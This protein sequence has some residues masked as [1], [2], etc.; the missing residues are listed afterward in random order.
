MKRTIRLTESDLHRIVKECVN[1]ALNEV[2]YGGESFHGDNPEDWDAIKQIRQKRLNRDGNQPYRYKD[3]DGVLRAN[4]TIEDNFPNYRG[5]FSANV[6]A[7]RAYRA[8]N[9]GR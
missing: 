6:K 1:Q 4:N 5:S 7:G 8:A 2:T 9:D 3:Y